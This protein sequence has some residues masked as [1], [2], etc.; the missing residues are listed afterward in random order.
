MKRLLVLVMVLLALAAQTFVQPAAANWGSAS[1]DWWAD[2][3]AP[4]VNMTDN[5]DVYF[6]YDDITTDLR[7]AITWVRLNLLNPSD[8]QSYYALDG[9]TEHTDVIMRD[10][11]YTTVCEEFLP[12]PWTTSGID[13]VMGTTGCRALVS[14]S[15]RCDQHIVRIS[16]LTLDNP[17]FT[18]V[19]FDRNITCHEVGHAIGLG[20]R[21]EDA[22]MG[23]RSAFT[24]YSGHDLNHF[25]SNWATEPDDVP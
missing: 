12:G 22:C 7:D 15:Q 23:A 13:N 10:A 16:T 4:D 8:L 17:Y 20:H 2:G 14:G 19:A 1:G 21:P 5:K 6:Y 24:S 11:A 18:T 9:L 3:C 25:S